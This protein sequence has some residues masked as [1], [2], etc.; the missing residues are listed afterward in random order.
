MWVK[1]N[2]EIIL[3]TKEG[4]T[5][6]K[7]TAPVETGLHIIVEFLVGVASLSSPGTPPCMIFVNFLDD[8]TVHLP[9]REE[10]QKLPIT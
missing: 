4:I 7:R 3:V 8:L 9:D 2:G 1:K 10:C 5:S 6:A